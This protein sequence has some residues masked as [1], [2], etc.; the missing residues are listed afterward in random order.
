M[1]GGPDDGREIAFSFDRVHDVTH[2][3]ALPPTFLGM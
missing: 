2:N 1:V 3:N